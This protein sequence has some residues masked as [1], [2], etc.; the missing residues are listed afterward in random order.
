MRLSLIVA[1][2]TNRIIGKDGGL[3]W[4][5]PADLKRFKAVTMGHPVIMGRR[6]WDEVHTPLPGRTNIVLSRDSGFYAE[7]ATVVSSLAEALAAARATGTDEAFVVGGSQV[8]AETLPMV[9]R[10]YLT[11]IDFEPDGDTRFPDLDLSAFRLVSEELFE[12]D[13]KAP[14][15][16][17]FLVRDRQSR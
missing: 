12:N 17:R 5:L 4:H 13:P 3:P 2:A 14:A 15:P 9:D 6:T 11:L 7:G 10:L 1:M 16:Y 8:Y